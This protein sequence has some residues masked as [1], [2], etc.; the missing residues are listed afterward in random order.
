LE[1]ESQPEET[2]NGQNIENTSKP[3]SREDLLEDKIKQNKT[4]E[5]FKVDVKSTK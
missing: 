1:V 4:A 2:P 3:P 5:T